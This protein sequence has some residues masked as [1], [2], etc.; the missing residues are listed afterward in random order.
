MHNK[1][2]SLRNDKVKDR[3]AEKVLVQ[4]Y[5][6]SQMPHGSQIPESS[7]LIEVEITLISMM[8]LFESVFH[9]EGMY[10][11]I[12]KNMGYM[13]QGKERFCFVVS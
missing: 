10:K 12:N 5:L 8:I 11:R 1:V 2:L 3:G 4:N 7:G 6:L 13:S 9:L